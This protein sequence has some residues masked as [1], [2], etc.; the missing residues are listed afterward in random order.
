VDCT[1]IKKNNLIRYSIILITIVMITFVIGMLS[2]CSQGA[3][4]EVITEEVTEVVPTER[5]NPPAYPPY[6][7]YSI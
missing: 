7:T 4:E 2:G 5:V 6:P 1:L 3:P